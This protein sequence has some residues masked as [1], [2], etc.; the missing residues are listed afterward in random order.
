MASKAYRYIDS[1]R[2]FE[3]HVL[4]ESVAQCV[5]LMAVYCTYKCQ[6]VLGIWLMDVAIDDVSILPDRRIRIRK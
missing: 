1:Y 4:P 6:H 5:S 3:R 2:G